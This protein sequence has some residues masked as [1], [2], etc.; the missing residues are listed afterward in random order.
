M[1]PKDLRFSQ[2]NHPD[3]SVL[4]DLGAAELISR[5]SRYVVSRIDTHDGVMVVKQTTAESADAGA[6]SALRHEYAVLQALDLPG[7]VKVLGLSDQGERL[8]LAMSDAGSQTL[9]DRLKAGSLSIGETLELA[10]QLSEIVSALH[11]ERIVHGNLNPSNIV[12]TGPRATV[13]NFALASRLSALERDT[14]RPAQSSANLHYSSPEQTG[15]TGRRVDSRTDLYALGALF[16]ELLTGSPPFSGHDPVKLVH[17][18]LALLPTPAHQ[19]RPDVPECLSQILLKLLEKEPEQRYQHAE[20]LTADLSEARRQWESHGAIESFPLARHDAPRDFKIGDRLYGRDHQLQALGQAFERV[21]AGQRELVLITGEPGIGKSALVHHLERPVLDQQGRFIAGKFDQLQRS[22]PYSGLVQALRVLVRQILSEPEEPLSLWRARILEAVAPNGQVLIELVPEVRHVIG[23]QPPAPVI[24]PV[25]SVNRLNR[26]FTSFLRVFARPEHPL[27]LFLDDLQWADA[28]SLQLIERWIGDAENRYLFLLGAYRDEEVGLSHPLS[29]MLTGLRTA[30]PAPQEIHLGPMT[31]EDVAALSADALNQSTA[32][33]HPLAALVFNRTAG[34]PFFVRRMLH[35]L[36]AQGL[37]RFDLTARCWR[38]EQVELEQAPLSGNVIELMVQTLN[39]LPEPTRALLQAAACLGHRFGLEALA[40]VTGHTREHAMDVLWPAMEDG[41]LLPLSDACNAPA[42]PHPHPHPH[43]PASA[44]TPATLQFVHDRVQQAAYSLMSQAHRSALH[45]N[46]GRRLLARAE[47]EPQDGLLFEV[48]DQLNLGQDLITDPAE[49]ISLSCLNCAAGS[50]ARASAA[51]QAAFDYFSAGLGQLPEAAWLDYHDLSF[52]LHR[53]LADC[54]YLTGSHPL[55]DSLVHTALGHAPSKSA[56]ADLYTLR[57]L[58]AMVAGDSTHALDI[59]REGLALFDLQWPDQS[60]ENALEHE[61]ANVSINLGARSIA[62]LNDV[63]QVDDPDMQAAMRL[64][65]ILGPPA[66]FSGADE[67]LAFVTLKG[68]NLALVHGPSPY[69]AYVCVFHGALH[70]ARTG[71]YDTGYAYGALAVDLARRFGD[72]A[73]LARTLQVFSLLVSVWNAPLRNT[74]PLMREGYRAAVESGELAY[75]AFTLAGLLINSLAAGVTLPELLNEAEIGLDFVIRQKNRIG[76]AIILPFRQMA[77]ALTGQTR[78]PASFDDDEFNEAEFLDHSKGNDTAIGHYWVARMQAAYLTGD[79]QLAEHCSVNALGAITGIQGMITSA[80]HVFYSALLLTRRYADAPADQQLASQVALAQLMVELSTWALHCP[81]TFAHKLSLIQAEQARIE[82]NTWRALKLYLHAIEGA[83]QHGFVQ[84][85]ALAHELRGRFLL[86]EAEPGLASLHLRE[87]RDAYGR[88]GAL[89]KVRQLEQDYPD[90]FITTTP[91]TGPQSEALDTLGLI[92]SSQA[93]SAETLPARL[94]ERILRIV[95]EVAGAQTGVLVLEGQGVLSVRARVSSQESAWTMEAT[96]VAECEALPHAILRYVARVRESLVLADA[97]NAGLFINDPDVR[98][99]GTRSVLCVPL[100]RQAHFAGLIYLE[101]NAIADAFT[102]QRVEIVQALAS[103]AV[104]SLEN[105][106]LLLEREQSEAALLEADRR[107]DEFLAMLAHELRSP[108][109]AITNTVYLLD[110]RT[111]GP[112]A[113][114]YIDILNRQTD[115]LRGLVDG[116]LDV[117]RIT[118]GLIELK[119]ERIDLVSV[120]ER[121][122]ESVQGLIDDKDHDLSVTLPRKAVPIIGDTVRIEQVLV[123][124]LTNAAKYTDNQGR[125]SLSLQVEGNDAYIR[126]RDNGIGMTAEVRERIF[127]LFGQAERGLAR[128]QGGLGIGLTIVKS[129]T[130]QHNGQVRV[131]SPGLGQGSEFVVVLPLA[132]VET[133][134]FEPAVPDAVPELLNGKR[135][136]VV[137]DMVDIAETLA[138]L[139]EDAGH[140]VWIAHDGPSALI[141]AE[142]H[143][144]DVIL[145]DIGLPGMDGYEVA[146]QLRAN[147]RMHGK[148]IAA[149]S[150]YGQASD[151]TRAHQAGF[152]RH[153]TKPVSISELEAFV[154][155]ADETA[156]TR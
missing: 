64:L 59:G 38:W 122:L 57:V 156:G 145:L 148:T 1:S 95:V 19:L 18:H 143:N 153:F 91:L 133:P 105:S 106:T 35:S 127:D 144:P 146:R 79:A 92:R 39:L 23:V 58:A 80:E 43:Q 8:A 76:I 155:A 102:A 97:G 113:R 154:N 77:R 137:D 61:A 20:A 21:C 112:D 103:Q 71:D 62:E 5:S 34:N 138:L 84:D 37:I 40:E 27:V 9:G 44:G 3:M 101:N 41:L 141:Q 32:V 114:R 30:H 147:P 140:R 47:G 51:Y 52:T 6:L 31:L 25:E 7:V 13:I 46:I 63:P 69:S 16:T 119:Q 29:L 55:A 67:I 99:L 150:G 116:L 94:F 123:N 135:V 124:L 96:P 126:V 136:L 117:S 139:L 50:K 75:A 36:H 120:V 74:L 66:Y 24:G 45:L 33:V 89:V 65:S 54:A 11:R 134:V 142:A 125:I 28:A 60:I 17:A 121:A 87:A 10:V 78:G 70:Q 81:S 152:D 48:A 151:Q 56:K 111:E 130:E 110:R 2:T 68:T 132:A 149:L 26:V 14:V 86:A 22:V 88:W 73:E 129:L 53:E 15:R 72:R 108:L 131:L 82:G 100:K 49:R 109:G 12:L 115:M 93:I 107:K 83:Q 4:I 42:S 118:R 104:I 85:Q 98:T 128:S 90:V